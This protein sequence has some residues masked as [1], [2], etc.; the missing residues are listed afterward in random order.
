[1][2]IISLMVVLVVVGL[3]LWQVNNYI[4]MEGRIK[5]IL[6]TV[7]VIMVI[8]WVL[9]AVGVMGVIP[10][11]LLSVLGTLVV[12]GLLLCLVN[13]Y[14]PMEGRIKQILNIIVIIL[15]VLWLLN[16]F[17]VL[18]GLPLVRIGNP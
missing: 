2:N 12:V 13:N 15:V 18:S 16:V 8:L 3:L 11:P 17:G 4:P 6:N 10:V 1:M 5:Q 14:I 7:V 9:N